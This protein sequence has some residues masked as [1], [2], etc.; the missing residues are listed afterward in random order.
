MNYRYDWM[1]N[2]DNMLKFNG[3]SIAKDA[4]RMAIQLNGLLNAVYDMPS[5]L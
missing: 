5:L 1:K 2:D 3:K 4:G